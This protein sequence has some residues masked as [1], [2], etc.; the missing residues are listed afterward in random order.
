MTKSPCY[1]TIKNTIQSPSSTY[2]DIFN[3][4]GIDTIVHICVDMNWKIT[5][6]TGDCAQIF[7]TS[8]ESLSGIFM[9]K[10]FQD[11]EHLKFYASL[12]EA[13]ESELPVQFEE[14]YAP[15]RT[16]VSV[17]TCKDMN[18][19]NISLKDITAIKK[20]HF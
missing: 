13:M 17:N 18:T 20:K 19:L 9:W 11:M 10:L 16:W 4:Q 6:Y 12:F 3:Y 7:G 5:N 14:Y 1:K 8:N 15:T 2:N